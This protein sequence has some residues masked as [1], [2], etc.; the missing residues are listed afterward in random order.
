MLK[1]DGAVFGRSCFEKWDAYSIRS[2]PR[3]GRRFKLSRSLIRFPSCQL[4]PTLK[5][6]GGNFGLQSKNDFMWW[7]LSWCLHVSSCYPF[8]IVMISFWYFM[9]SIEF[10]WI[11][12]NALWFTFV[13]PRME[14][15]F[16]HVL[17]KKPSSIRKL[18]FLFGKTSLFDLFSSLS[19]LFSLS[20]TPVLL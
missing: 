8:K 15:S 11:S 9:I 17:P 4:C 13:F 16:P 18:F 14:P 5:T 2:L 6:H 20:K 7:N 10:Q 3:C 12:L 1:N 19:A